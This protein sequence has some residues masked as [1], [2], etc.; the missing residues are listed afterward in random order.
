MTIY[1]VIPDEAPVFN[2][3]K[4]IKLPS[5]YDVQPLIVPTSW[6]C[7]SCGAVDEATIYQVPLPGSPIHNHAGVDYRGRKYVH[8][9]YRAR[10]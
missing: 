3:A 10:R 8:T 9:V 1:P 4:R 2:L 5:T 6:R 7:H